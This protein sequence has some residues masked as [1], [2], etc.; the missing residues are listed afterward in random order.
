MSGYMNAPLQQLFMIPAFRS[1]LLA[2]DQYKD[3]GDPA[4]MNESLIYQVQLLFG[5]LQESEQQSCSPGG[6][7]HAF[8][9]LDGKPTDVRIQDD[10]GGFVQR[11]LDRM[12]MSTKGTPFEKDIPAV[13]GGVLCHELIG[14]GEC[15]HYRD[16]SEDFYGISLE[17]QNKKTL[18]ESLQAFVEGEVLEGG[19]QYKCDKCTRI[20][21]PAHKPAQR[22]GCSSLSAHLTCDSLLRLSA[23]ATRRWTLSSAS[24]YAP[25]PPHCSSSSNASS[26]TTTRWRPSRST[27]G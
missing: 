21:T 18:T 1:A 26:W 3:A 25:F 2:I 13:L 9:D 17:V 19:N 5:M 22:Q 15:H 4:D 12:I 20:R 16:R 8:K 23:D 10:S 7:C 27:T 14:K 24:A 6:V 11:L